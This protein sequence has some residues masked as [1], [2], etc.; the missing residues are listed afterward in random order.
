ME[1]FLGVLSG[2]LPFAAALM[3]GLRLRKISRSENSN[4]ASWTMW[5]VLNFIIAFS[6]FAAGNTE[7]WLPVG[8]T[9]SCVFIAL[10]L[11]TRGTWKW[12]YVETVCALGSLI[13]IMLRFTVSS[14]NGAVMVSCL[15]MWI[16]SGPII[17]DAWKE[18][19]FGSWWLWA[20]GAVSAILALYVAPEWSI[21]G[22]LF[23]TS[24]LLFNG[25]MTI[26]CARYLARPI[27]YTRA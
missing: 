7:A 4:L 18:P 12:G 13:A 25:I 24:S 20:S 2:A 15:A 23:P 9:A 6:M 1:K 16:A 3:Y 26:L 14:D 17:R 10:T 5:A 21:E 19:D 22:R 27:E 11:L 8:Y